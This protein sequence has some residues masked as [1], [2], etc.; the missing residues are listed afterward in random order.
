M[1]ATLGKGISHMDCAKCWR[2]R[3]GME[4][5]EGT[6]CRGMT[7]SKDFL[8][9]PGAPRC[10]PSISVFTPPV[11]LGQDQPCHFTSLQ[12]TPSRCRHASMPVCPVERG[13]DLILPFH[14]ALM[15]EIAG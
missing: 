7:A 3:P 12:Q 15:T 4:S 13:E 1:G 14:P 10:S 11:P 2:L 8:H 9:N 6:E 5:P